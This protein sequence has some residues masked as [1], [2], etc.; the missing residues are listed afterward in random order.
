MVVMVCSANFK[1]AKLCSDLALPVKR[2]LDDLD[3]RVRNVKFTRLDFLNL[4]G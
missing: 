4:H 2:P 3:D 1:L